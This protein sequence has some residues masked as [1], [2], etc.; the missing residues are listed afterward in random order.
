MLF[1]NLV[2]SETAYELLF[3]ES[4][5]VYVYEEGVFGNDRTQD[6]D[7]D[8]GYPLWTVRVTASDARNREQQTLE[9]RVAAKDKPDAGF[10]EPVRLPNL[11]VQ[12]YTRRADRGIT[13]MWFADAFAVGGP[14]KPAAAPSVSS[15]ASSAKAA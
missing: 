11:R 5:P 12:A 4:E 6:R 7:P 2:V 1:K 9:V 8:T 14:S 15:S 10:Q 13:T 3:Q